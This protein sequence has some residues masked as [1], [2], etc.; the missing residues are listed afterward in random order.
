M[1]KS[2][3]QSSD[4][5]GSGG[6]P[7]SNSLLRNPICFQWSFLA[8]LIG[9]RYHIIPQ[10]AGTIPLIYCLLGD[11][12]SPIPPIKGTNRNSCLDVLFRFKPLHLIIHFQDLLGWIQGL[13][14]VGCSLHIQKLSSVTKGYKQNIP[15][16]WCVNWRRSK[17]LGIMYIC[18]SVYN[19]WCI[20]YDTELYCIHSYHLDNGDFLES[21]LLSFPS[22]TT[23]QW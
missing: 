18:G 23:L 9:V 22:N 19:I 3:A 5:N 12:I 13:G 15:M 2:S 20:Y 4:F 6:R 14:I 7:R 17:P 16:E 8:P 10:L 1:H 21:W 11:Y